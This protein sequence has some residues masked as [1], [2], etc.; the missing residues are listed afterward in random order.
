VPVNLTTAQRTRLLRQ[1]RRNYQRALTSRGE[2][3]TRHAERYQRYLA[4]VTTRPEGPYAEAPRIFVPLTRDIIEKQ[5]ATFHQT[6]FGNPDQLKLTPV[7]NEDATQ[8]E[9]D[10]R[11]LRWALRKTVNFLEAKYS[12][13]A[14][15]YTAIQDALMDSV[16]VLKVYHKQQPWRAAGPSKRFLKSIIQI[17]SVDLGSFLVPPD[18]EGL[19]YPQCTYV[20]QEIWQTWD[21]MQRLETHGTSKKA[22][23]YTVP[24]NEDQFKKGSRSREVTDRK[25][26]EL[27]RDGQTLDLGEEFYALTLESYERFEVDRDVGE[28]DLIV[29]WFPDAEDGYEFARVVQLSDVF[30]VLERPLRP[31]FAITVW[32][33]A[34]QWRGM[35]AVD[36]LESMQDIVN[37]LHEQMI[38]YA[39]VSLMPFFF[40]QAYVTG[41]IP[42]NLRQI[43]P[44]EGIPVLGQGGIEFV[45]ARPLSRHFPEMIQQMLANAERDSSVNDFS[46]GR[47]SDRPNAPRTYGATMAL[48]ASGRQSFAPLMLHQSS[49]FCEMLG[50]FYALWQDRLGRNEVYAPIFPAELGGRESAPPQSAFMAPEMGLLGLN[51]N[52]NGQNPQ[53]LLEEVGFPLDELQKLSPK[54]FGDL[55]QRVIRPR[56]PASNP[57]RSEYVKPEDL[58][59]LF[60]VYMEVDPNEQFNRQMLLTFAQQ[61]DPK[62]SLIW[63]MGARE[64]WKRTWESAKQSN[65]DDIWPKAI[66]EIQTLLLAKQIQ[67]QIGMGAMP[68][69]GMEGQ[70]GAVP[71]PGGGTGTQAVPSA[72]MPPA[73]QFIGMP[74]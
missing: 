30:P 16:G 56:A 19:Q 66:A 35:S 46:L 42:G 8:A 71:P 18:A 39:E 67:A 38:S 6:Q 48:L 36:R 11:F 73:E 3:P 65:F 58:S 14:L 74:S 51:G 47:Q 29:T 33:Q 27:E 10:S 32:P 60:D 21:Q 1:V 57:F 31:F 45:N 12:Q 28:E 49:Q 43:R 70:A 4:D 52:G 44:G 26:A 20:H 40:Y 69:P 68:A 54:A 23:T 62:L 64:I 15:A 34:R 13:P 25:R 55:F 53:G 22:L 37:R 59:G 9:L 72:G 7:G 5:T 61:L 63:P 2:F 24:K 50:F 41:D 17:D